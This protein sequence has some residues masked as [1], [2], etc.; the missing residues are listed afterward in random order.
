MCLFRSAPVR[1]E[2]GAPGPG[3]CG[4]A[5]SRTAYAACSVRILQPSRTQRVRFK[6]VNKQFF[7]HTAECLCFLGGVLVWTRI[8]VAVQR[9][10]R[11]WPILEEY[12]AF[13][14]QIGVAA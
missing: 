3:F 14:L 9:R 6:Q 7:C 8:E 13:L 10:G 4:L 11:P 1:G 5:R 2:L 12:T